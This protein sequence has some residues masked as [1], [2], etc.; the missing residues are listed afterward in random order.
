MAQA[1]APGSVGVKAIPTADLEPNPHNPRRL[2]DPEPLNTLRESIAKVGILV[3]LTVYWSKSRKTWV[4]LDGQ[5]RWIC[6]QKLRLKTVP[7]NEVAEPSLVQNIVTM[8]QIHKLRED[9]EL[10][11]TA[12]TLDIL[13]SALKERRDARLAELTGL[14]RAVVVRC[15]KLLS[16]PKKYQDMMLDSDPDKRVKADFFIELYAVL[17]DRTVRRMTW[18]RPDTFTSKMLRRY[19]EGGL[20]SVTDFRKIKQH[21]NT[22]VRAGKTKVITD[23]LAQFADEPRLPV[24]HLAIQSAALSARVRE[25][26]AATTKLETLLRNLNAMDYYAEDDLWTRLEALMQL[27][28]VRLEEVERRVK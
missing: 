7:A 1:L 18:F 27:I 28:R 22:A 13:M 5:R 11:P 24:E 26:T 25:I 9:W 4:I 12:L 3:P 10:M 8:F 23:R 2:F 21:I 16:F 6:A 20:K 19:S 14:D 15:K 17:R